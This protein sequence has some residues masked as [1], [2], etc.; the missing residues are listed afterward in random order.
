MFFVPLY[1][2]LLRSRP[3]LMFWFAALTQ[4]FIWLVVPAVFYFA[5]PGDLA[6]LLAIGRELRLASGVGPPLAY[7]LGEIA[8]R[9]AGLFGVYLLSQLCV[10]VTYWCV[11][12]LG[13][14][15]LGPAHAAIA[16]L[17]MIGIALLTVP[18]P[19]FGP[20]ILAMALWAVTLLHY[21]QAVVQGNKRS[22]YVAGA[23]AALIFLTTDA[24]LILVGTLAAFTVLTERGRAALQSTEPWIV[25]VALVFF[26]FL[27]LLWLEGIADG[28]VPILQTLRRTASGSDNTVA[29]L[30]ILI[31]L[32]LAHAGLAI[33]VVLA[34]GWPRSRA[35][36]APPLQRQPVDAFAGTFVK[37][38]AVVPA[39]LAT[40]IAV[41][42]ERPAPI[43]GAAPL[44]VLSGLAV[45]MAAGDSIA[46]YHQRVLGF[47]WTGLLLVPALFVPLLI[48]LLPWA[49]ATDLKVAQPARAMGRFFAENFERR[50]GQPLAIVTGDPRTAALIA[51]AAPSRPSVLFDAAPERSPWVTADDI[52]TRGAI[53]VWLAADTTPT[54]P[55][56]IKAHFPD[57]VPEVPRTFDRPVQGRMPPL[58]IGW[59]VIRP[60]SVAAAPAPAAPTAAAASR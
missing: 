44:V 53:V 23:A 13:R 31:A 21:W 43:G 14:A 49:A 24:A 9:I 34:V 45:V 28:L 54:P 19:D 15:V 10:V 4:A 38:V 16:V 56:D 36:P 7:W 39:L 8:F 48:F 51:L 17:L 27:H 11:F 52:R 12:A 25:A 58:R 18:T 37:V 26:L 3:Q 41:M 50:T 1:L 40:V 47:A 57:L 46:L 35:T 2:E 42:I 33:L 55:P 30:R 22:W 6:Q 60:G 29:W 5:P 20:A 32:A 59:A